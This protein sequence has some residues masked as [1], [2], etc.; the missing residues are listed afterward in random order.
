MI[1]VAKPGW[2]GQKLVEFL[3]NSQHDALHFPTF[4]IASIPI[5][6]HQLATETIS[7]VIF[8]SQHAVDF[9]LPN[10][11][12]AIQNQ[13]KQYRLWCIGASTAA[14][15]AEYGYQA[16]FPEQA[17]SEGFLA[18]LN[19]ASAKKR[20]FLLVKGQGGRD[21]IAQQLSRLNQVTKIECYQR[22]SRSFQMLNEQLKQCGTWPWL[23]IAT[24]PS[25][26]ECALPLFKSYPKWQQQCAITVTNPR[27]HQWAKNNGFSRIYPLQLPL[28]DHALLQQVQR[29]KDDIDDE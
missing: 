26:L 25:A 27:M 20:H 18:M 11:S 7:D 4:D 12:L 3:I 14:R 22:A 15:L 17:N 8:T 9:F 6:T 1:A 28:N 19:I 10:I 16:K 2:K 21:I 29:I 24:S 5:K 13:L 23:L